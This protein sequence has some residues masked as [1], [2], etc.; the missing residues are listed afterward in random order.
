M[1]RFD[2]LGMQFFD[3]SGEILDQ[4][5]IT[6]YNSGTTVKKNT[7]ADINQ[8]VVNSNPLTL[9]LAG[10]PPSIFFSGAAKAVV[11]DKLGALIVSLD[12]V[13]ETGTDQ[14]FSEWL[15]T[16][17]YALDD[18]VLYGSK[19]YISLENSNLGN[20]PSSS[21]TKWRLFAN[22][23]LKD[24]TEI[25]A[26][27]IFVSSSPGVTGLNITAKGSIAAGNGTTPTSLAVGAN[28]TIIV[29]DS[30]QAT[31]LKYSALKTVGGTSLLGAGNVA[32]TSPYADVLSTQTVS[33][34]SQV[35]VETG[36]SS[37]Y[38]SYIIEGEGIT[39]SADDSLRF[40]Y[41]VS[42]AYITTGTYASPGGTFSGTSITVTGT[43]NRFGFQF[44][45][46]DTNS[47]VVKLCQVNSYCINAADTLQ[48]MTD[49]AGTNST[50]SAIQ[51]IRLF[52][53][54][55]A[56]ISGKVTLYG[57]RKT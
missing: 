40:R 38:D 29:A 57:I 37:T 1:A 54:G 44:I 5:T 4:G 52:A 9:S 45:I 51:G 30:A 46:K 43:G 53:N 41:K 22:D 36:F 56:T 23:L 33:A 19:F 18:V 27:H 32:T 3:A 13:G 48:T 24:Q 39:L 2:T 20:T 47:A 49:T 11:R 26:N 6:F 55:G 12:P 31:G 35:D 21:P 34:V 28:D 16:F 8:S 17:G 42:G 15:D 25:T 14:Q 7:Y 50:T 10:R